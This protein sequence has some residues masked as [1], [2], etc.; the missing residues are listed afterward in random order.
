MERK[1]KVAVI[2]KNIEKY[3]MEF[4][5][6]ALS[7]LCGDYGSRI[8]LVERAKESIPYIPNII[9]LHKLEK[10]ITGIQE[11]SSIAS[12]VSS[13]LF[14]DTDFKTNI[15]TTEHILS[16]I[17]KINEINKVDY[18]VDTTRALLNDEI[19]RK[20]YF[21]II[22]AISKV[23]DMDLEFLKSQALNIEKIPGCNEVYSLVGI[24]AMISA[25][26]KPE[27]DVERQD[28]Y[29]TEFGRNIDRFALSYKSDVRQK[30]HKDINNSYEERY[31]ETGLE[32]IGNDEINE[33]VNNAFNK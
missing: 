28:Y 8:K 32:S 26:N 17:Y 3:I 33:S 14:S 9:F 20:L 6:T 15:A 2:D 18:I 23:L 24:G 13:K 7:A 30:G 16:I 10:F 27:A 21:R 22:D 4:L 11:D 31:F 29:I 25:G 12:K 1:D 5:E 19:D